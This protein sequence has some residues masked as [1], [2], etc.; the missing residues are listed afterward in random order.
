MLKKV[1]SLV[2]SL[3]IVMSVMCIGFS[4]SAN[5]PANTSDNEVI[6]RYQVI[7]SHTSGIH[8]SGITA[9]CTAGLG[10]MYS[11]NL[12]IKMEL[13]KLSSGTYSTIKTWSTSKTGTS[14]DLEGTKLINVLS[15]YRLKTTFTAGN[16]TVVVYSNPT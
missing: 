3:V 13:Q 9:T 10:A 8:I 1:L 16:E 4:V 12:S 5:E 2:L 11:T 14:L 15:T 7:G 6:Y